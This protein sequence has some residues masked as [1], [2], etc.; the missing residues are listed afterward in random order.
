MGQESGFFTREEETVKLSRNVGK[1]Y[2][3]SLRNSPEKHSSYL[4]RVE[5]RNHAHKSAT[6]LGSECANVF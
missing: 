5:A 4:Q 3:Y 1:I 2:H 6:L